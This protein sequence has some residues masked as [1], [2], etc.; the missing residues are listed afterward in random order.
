MLPITTAAV[1]KLCNSSIGV[2]PLIHPSILLFNAVVQVLA[3]PYSHSLRQLIILLQVGI[4]EATDVS[5]AEY[6]IGR[7]RELICCKE[8]VSS[9]T[10][11]A[12]CRNDLATF[13]RDAPKTDDVTLFVLGRSN[14][15][16][17]AGRRVAGVEIRDVG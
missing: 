16:P 5:G 12:A 17:E 3:G 4:S 15:E 8:V 6:G 2:K 9:A 14:V 1:G 13:C 10:L 11:L 7:L